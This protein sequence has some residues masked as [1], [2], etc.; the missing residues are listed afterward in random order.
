MP[1]L[2]ARRPWS[3][4]LY[5]TRTSCCQTCSSRTML[6]ALGSAAL[7]PRI[8]DRVSEKSPV[9]TPSRYNT[10]MRASTLGSLRRNGGRI[11]LVKRRLPLR[12]RTRGCSMQSCPTPVMSSRWGRCQLRTMSRR[13][14]ESTTLRSSD[15]IC[16]CF[17]RF[18]QQ[19]SGSF[20]GNFVERGSAI[21]Y[22]LSTCHR[23]YVTFTHE[24]ILFAAWTRVFDNG[25]IRS[26][27]SEPKHNIG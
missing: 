9:D 8:A 2:L 15:T 11:L 1:R 25:R 4:W 17:Q 12:L 26:I 6:V 21:V 3:V 27:F 13:P 7:G 20:M 23:S 5:E 18:L 10:R 22:L 19:A 24:R 16:T 14:C